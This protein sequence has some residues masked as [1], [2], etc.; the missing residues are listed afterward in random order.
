MRGIVI[1]GL[2]CGF[3]GLWGCGGASAHVEAAVLSPGAAVARFDRGMEA[4]GFRRVGAVA[5]VPAIGSGQ[6]VAHALQAPAA[7]CYEA[8]ALTVGEDR[9]SIAALDGDDSVVGTGSVGA[10]PSAFFCTSGSGAYRFVVASEGGAA[11]YYLVV[12]ASGP[13]AEESVQEVIAA[14]EEAPAAAAVDVPQHIAADAVAGRAGTERCRERDPTVIDP[15]CPQGRG[16]ARGTDETEATQPG[17]EAADDAATVAVTETETPEQRT[18]RARALFEQGL[19][20]VRRGNPALGVVYLSQAFDLA[21][22]AGVLI[23]LAAA[24]ARLGHHVKAA[25]AYAQ[26]LTMDDEGITPRTQ[27][28]ARRGLRAL[29]RHVS[30]IHF[31]LPGTTGFARLD[32]EPLEMWSN[33]I[34]YPV[35]AGVHDLTYA[36]DGRLRA[37]GHVVVRLGQH[38]DL[39]LEVVQD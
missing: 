21:H 9:V 13:D 25:Q 24:E 1:W 14:S 34:D 4:R 15:W 18:E 28:A 11:E 38:A 17:D 19:D 27:Q 39:E 26:Y 16:E 37:T 7:S 8:L 23:N 2:I 33:D 20:W 10:S 32:G 35:A 5:H 29:R 31:R 36:V 3:W 6:S 22:R 12:Y 30:F